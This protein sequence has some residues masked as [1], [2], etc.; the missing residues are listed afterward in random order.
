MFIGAGVILG[1]MIG[2]F[3][4]AWRQAG[5]GGAEGGYDD[6]GLGN[7]YGIFGVYGG[8][9]R[10]GSGGSSGSGGG[11]ISYT[12]SLIEKLY[13]DPVN[14]DSLAEKI[15]PLILEELDPHSVYIPAADLA[16]VSE[17]LEGEFDGIG[18][19]FNMLTDTVVVL[20]VI[21]SGPSD[22]AG[23]Q[24]G[25]R[26]IRID[27]SLVAGRKIAQD[28][29]VKRLRGPRGTLVT[30]GIER[31]G[32]QDLVQIVVERG[33][34]PLKALDAAFMIAPGV[35]FVKLS[36][37]SRLSFEELQKALAELSAQGM[38]RLIFDLRDN[39]GGYLGQAIEMA[40][41][42]LRKDELIVYTEDRAGR[43]TR[44]YSNGRGGFTEIPLVVLIDEGS[45]SSSEILAGAIQDNDRGMIIGRR[46]FGKG[47]VQ[48]EIP[49]P[50]GSAVR[51]T[52]ARY[53]TPSGRSIQKPYDHGV[54]EY[55]M[56][57]YNR[58][59]AGEVFSTSAD[60]VTLRQD[61]VS[62]FTRGGRVVHGGGGIMPDYFVPVDT[63]GITPYYQRVNGRN[64]INLFTM[65]W[66]DRHRTEMN[67]VSSIEELAAMFSRYPGLTDEFVAYAARNGVAPD[68]QQIAISRQLIEAQLRALT[69]R[70]T[71]LDYNGYFANIYVIDSTILK[72]IEVLN[73]MPDE[74]SN[75][76]TEVSNKALNEGRTKR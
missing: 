36:S 32:A 18:V 11:K 6:G 51:L 10:D 22:K 70:N 52:I 28:A 13:V 5:P 73:G 62:Y 14:S 9:D 3:A 23:V 12:M 75:V 31:Q 44:E 47:L 35:G 33:V 40:N 50:D 55:Q 61:T 20:N 54:A 38:R 72:A 65:D 66:G 43:Q 46:S 19:M 45:A 68:R 2:V 71:A 34:I 74:M 56:D 24:N 67:T 76:A 27:D 58:F 49:Y 48:R 21:P 17:P 4:F 7:F 30:L 16:A 42:F 63:V 29:I 57:I 26:I 8:G 25:D 41:M 15:I 39:G 37:F 53:Y 60:S 1:L 69:G 59:A 64:L